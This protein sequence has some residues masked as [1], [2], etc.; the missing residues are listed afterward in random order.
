MTSPA[1]SSFLLSLRAVVAG[2]AA[3]AALALAPAAVRA[4]GATVGEIAIGHPWARS[5]VPG[6]TTGAG[7]LKL[8]NRGGADRLLGARTE[9]A[10]RVELHEM[11][12][13][14]DVMR[15]RQRD[16]IDVPA[17][18]RVELK[19]G[20]A[21]L[22][23]VGLKAPLAVGEKFPLTLTFEKAGPVEVTV[24]VQAGP[25]PARGSSSAPGGAAGHG[26]MHH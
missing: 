13:E 15:M 17:G 21:H 23:L 20:G 26:A 7:Y 6:Q 8:D 4:H 2:A 3:A 25:L 12:M 1:P 16:A 24:N 10:E 14:A 11:W 22:M 5:T 9:R 18:G 19:P